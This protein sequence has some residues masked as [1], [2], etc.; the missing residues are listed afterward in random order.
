MRKWGCCNRNSCCNTCC[1]S[2]CCRQR[3]CTEASCCNLVCYCSRFLNVPMY[4][5][6]GP[7]F[8]ETDCCIAQLG[9]MRE[10]SASLRAIACR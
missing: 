7:G 10:M 4:T 5:Y 6:Y 9:V 8:T 3:Y 2:C 1:N